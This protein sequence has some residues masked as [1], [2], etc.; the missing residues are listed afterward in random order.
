MAIRSRERIASLINSV[1]YA[2]HIPV[3]LE[4]LRQ[5]ENELS[6]ADSVLLSDFLP[7]ILQLQ[8]D[9]FSPVRRSITEMVGNIGQKH[10][11]Y[12]D[13]V[14][15]VLLT[16]IGDDTPAVVRKAITCGTILFRTIL[17]KIAIQGLHSGELDDSIASSWTRVLKLRDEINSIVFQLDYK[18]GCDG[19]KL[20][21]VKFIE[22][23]VLLYTPDPSGPSEPPP[24]KSSVEEFPEFNISWL[25]GGH[26]ILKVGDLSVEAGRSLGQLLDLLRMPTVKSLGHSMVIVLINS[27]SGIAM[28]RPAFFG[29]ILPVLLDLDPSTAVIKGLSVNAEHLALRNAF[30]SC[31]ECTHP[32][33]MPWRNRLVEALR[34]KSEG[35]AE[36]AIDPAYQTNGSAIAKE[37][38]ATVQEDKRS[39]EERDDL[40]GSSGRK[41]PHDTVEDGDGSVKRIRSTPVLTEETT[42]NFNKSQNGASSG[43]S[44]KIVKDNGHVQKLVTM[45]SLLAAQGEETAGTIE[46]LASSISTDLLAEV[47]MSNMTNLP[48]VRPKVEADDGLSSR[49]NVD[50]EFKKLYSFLLSLLTL[51]SESQPMDCG[52]DVQR[53]SSDI[54]VDDDDHKLASLTPC[55]KVLPGVCHGTD[56]TFISSTEMSVTC[57]VSAPSTSGVGLSTMPFQVPDVGN[58]MSEIPGLD[59][60]V[61]DSV[62]HHTPEL[63]KTLTIPS[64]PPSELEDQNQPQ[65]SSLGL[66]S[67]EFLASI[68]TDRSEELTNDVNGI[69]GSTASSVSLPV[70]FVLP[71]MSAPVISITDE[72]RDH[73]QKL[74]FMRIIEAYKQISF[75]GGSEARFSLLVYLGVEFKNE[76]DPWKLLQEHILSDYVNHEGHEFTVRVLYRLYGEA[77]AEQDFFCSTNATSVYA[78]FLLTVA[79]TLRDSFPASDKSLS[80]LLCEAPHLPVSIFK[81]LEC[82]CC[83]ESINK[84]E[85]E[86]LGGDRVTQGLSLVWSLILLRPPIRDGCLKI[87]LQ[88]AVH[89]L[90]EVRMKAIR[91]VAN[92]LFPLASIAQQIEDFA[93]DKLHSVSIVH[94]TETVDAE[95]SEDSSLEKPQEEQS[96]IGAISKTVPL[97]AHQSNISDNSPSSLTEAQRCMS[98]YFALCTKRHALLREIFVVYKDSP[99]AV[100]EAASHQ[101]PILVR[102]MGLSSELLEIIS[103]PPSG[104]EKLL[105]QVLQTLTDATTPSPELISTIINLY[106]TKLKDVEILIPI[107]PYLPK[108]EVLQIFPRL[109]L[110]PLDKFQ[111]AI[112]RVLQASNSSQAPTPAELL[113]AIHGIDPDRDGIPLKKVTDACNFC[114][115][116]REVFTQQV[117]AKVLNQLVEQIPLPMLFMRTVL[118]AIG[119]F[120]ALMDFIMEILSRLVNKQIWKYPK[121]W[122]GFLKCAQLTKPQ[123]FSVLLQ[124][125]PPQL[126]IALNRIPAL[127]DPLVAHASQPH[128]KASL[129]RS[130]L[131]VLGIA[132][133]SQNSGQVQTVQAQTGDASNSINN[134]SATEQSKESSAGAS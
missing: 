13:E 10:T 31:L 25:R 49:P 133:D 65:S 23:V 5:L 131:A 7:S 21:A 82:L 103:D 57:P 74:A 44:S 62:V 89:H 128:I 86:V 26:P 52:P 64:F 11:E 129:P 93:K 99:N 47:I 106:S 71:K 78:T 38:P 42:Q 94:A 81:L 84:D 56:Q 95:M 116:Q 27:L 59:S 2:M 100:K 72:E 108:K 1:K 19:V 3:K 122:V 70:Q 83:P 85:K 105:I 96:S 41:R 51:P 54:Q 134:E 76:L 132:L 127:R 110:L 46:I 77:E 67:V 68:S 29:R 69:N 125:Q 87:V 117:L 4:L 34:T 9:P 107:L 18:P 115:E 8:S 101:I 45:F 111:A 39:L 28:K 40:H 130:V 91:L 66:A 14:V 48:A 24:H 126:E 113:I 63:P 43:V 121:L 33:A 20:L 55:S 92:K 35:L 36:E 60:V 53:V 12:T 109:L 75:A 61:H 80:K 22:A 112:S 88:S 79:E 98:L 104:S 16:A 50:A 114:F 6:D 58:L 32:G 120:P 118:Q 119:V 123:S 15:D 17:W 30:I 97:D 90:E 124:L 37:D 102:T 73:L